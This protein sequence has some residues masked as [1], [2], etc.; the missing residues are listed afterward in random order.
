MAKVFNQVT[1]DLG[2]SLDKNCGA[3]EYTVYL[4]LV[5]NKKTLGNPSDVTTFSVLSKPENEEEFPQHIQAISESLT[6]DPLVSGL[7]LHK[8]VDHLLMNMFGQSNFKNKDIGNMMS[9]QEDFKDV[10]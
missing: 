4:N 8:T 6:S 3:G 7:V 1:T 10:N 5:W 9:Y 2:E